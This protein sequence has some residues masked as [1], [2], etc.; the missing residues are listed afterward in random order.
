D[1]ALHARLHAGH[2]GPTEPAA[3]LDAHALGPVLHRQVDRA[4]DRAAEAGPL[5]Q[6]LGD[7][8]GHQLGV[9]L[10]PADLERLDLDPPV[11]EVFEVLGQLVDLR[12]LLA[13]DHADLRRVNVDDHLLAGPL[14]LDLG[15]PRA[16]VFLF[17]VL[18]DLLVLDEEVREVLLVG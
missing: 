17:D 4:L 6:L 11:G 2:F 16:R 5:L 18:A 1:A 10:R 12:A 3:Q 15:D 7:V 8:L 13:D 9:D 14:D